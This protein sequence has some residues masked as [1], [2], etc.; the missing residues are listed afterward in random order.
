MILFVGL[1]VFGI[2]WLIKTSNQ[3]NSGY[4]LSHQTDRP[5]EILNERYAKGE[6]SDEEYSKMKAELKKSSI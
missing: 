1:V 3:R 4:S 5:L 2:Y 6:I